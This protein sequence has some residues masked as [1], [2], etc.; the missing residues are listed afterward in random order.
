MFGRTRQQPLRV[1]EAE[2]RRSTDSYLNQASEVLGMPEVQDALEILKIG[3]LPKLLRVAYV[4][5]VNEGFIEADKD[6]RFLPLVSLY[7]GEDLFIRD[8]KKPTSIEQK[9]SHLVSLNSDRN[10]NVQGVTLKSPTPLVGLSQPH[11]NEPGAPLTLIH[12]FTHV[13]QGDG[14][15]NRRADFSRYPE[16]KGPKETEA[17]NI[18]A[19]VADILIKTRGSRWYNNTRIL[20]PQSAKIRSRPPITPMPKSNSLY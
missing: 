20:S 7:P 9:S 4:P 1:N 2:R 8:Q 14:P 19:V 13:L 17:Y 3:H 16:F 11:H 15:V 5:P 18:E 10:T 6:A 12:E